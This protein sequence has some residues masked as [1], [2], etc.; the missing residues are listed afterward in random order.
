MLVAII[1]LLYVSNIIFIS[2]SLKADFHLT[3][4]SFI[5]FINIFFTY[6]FACTN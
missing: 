3:Y 5:L 6:P 1:R 2:E 4:D